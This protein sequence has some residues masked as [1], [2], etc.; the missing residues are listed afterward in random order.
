MGRPKTDSQRFL[1]KLDRSGECWLWKGTTDKDGYGKVMINYR[2]WKASRA[3]WHLLVGP[4]PEDMLVLH[5]C[6]VPSCCNPD[7]LWLGTQSENI[8]DMDSKGRR[9]K[10][11]PAKLTD[12]QVREIRKDAR[13]QKTI[14][15]DYGI[16]QQTVSKIQLGK[17]RIND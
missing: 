1:N 12:E 8:R 15:R 13:S 4:I 14:A 9:G 3:A 10:R 5:K 2:S 16:A 11:T 7:H 6:D 17:A